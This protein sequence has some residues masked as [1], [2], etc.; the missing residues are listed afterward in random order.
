MLEELGVADKIVLKLNTLGDAESRRHWRDALVCYFSDHADK[1]SEESTR[2]L[3]TNPMRILDSK[4][5]G[6]QQLARNAPRIDQY[7][8]LE[9][10][11]FFGRVEEGLR[12]ARIRY[13]RAPELVRGL[14]YYRHTTFEFVTTHLGAQG[15]V[16]GGGRYDGLIEAMGG[17]PT[18][19]VGWAGGIERL[20]LLL[21]ERRALAEI[22]AVVPES[23]RAEALAQQIA[24]SLRKGGI[25]V[26][27]LFRGTARKRLDRLQRRGLT[28]AVF[29]DVPEEHPEIIGT[30]NIKR[31]RNMSHSSEHRIARNLSAIFDVFKAFEVQEEAM[32]DGRR[33]DIVLRKK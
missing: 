23:D 11:E 12:N 21:P 4:D 29:V 7:L 18:P 17:L 2:R 1:L 22:V 28:T 15:T 30:V 20:A 9:A 8:T 27:Y 14:D 24:L 26:D 3:Q 32:V 33:A 19:A 31:Y 10:Q 25:P 13:E 6:D 16:I 5:E